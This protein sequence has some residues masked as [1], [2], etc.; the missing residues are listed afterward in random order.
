MTNSQV[1]H[2]DASSIEGRGQRVARNSDQMMISSA[3]TGKL[4]M[5]NSVRDIDLE[6]TEEYNILSAASNSFEE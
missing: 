5:Q 2:S 6:A 1:R 3:R 4:V